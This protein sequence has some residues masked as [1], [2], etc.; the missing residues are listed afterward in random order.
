M[1]QVIGCDAH[2]KFLVFAVNEKGHAGDALR[3]VHDRQ[4]YRAF[5]ARLPPQSAIA[6]EASGHYS[7]IV[8]EMERAGHRPKL[9]NALK[10]GGGSAE[11]AT[12]RGKDSEHGSDAGDRQG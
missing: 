6:V 10:G 1:E 11:D 9:A 8:D 7:W 4:L 5:L 2:K 3:V 12:L